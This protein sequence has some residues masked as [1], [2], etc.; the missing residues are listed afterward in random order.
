MNMAILVFGV[1]II[2]M[3]I[4]GVIAP[5]PMINMVLGFWHQPWGLFAAAGIRLALGILFLQAAVQTRHP[6]VFELLGY[7]MIFSAIVIV[8]TGR[9]RIDRFIKYWTTQSTGF[10]RA[11]LVIGV[12]FG[13]FIVYSVTGT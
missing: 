8:L 5:R 10:I 9:K 11:W 7:L 2:V 1:F 13:A 4:W 6:G 12:A 3:C